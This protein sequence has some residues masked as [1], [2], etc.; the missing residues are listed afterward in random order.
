MVEETHPLFDVPYFK[1]TNLLP[2]TSKLAVFGL[3]QLQALKDSFD[4]P[5]NSL[6]VEKTWFEKFEWR[7]LIK[8]L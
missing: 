1:P 4:T 8:L 2:E 7:R 5:K 6:T 3:I